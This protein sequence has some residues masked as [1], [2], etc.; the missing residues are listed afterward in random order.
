M[1]VKNKTGGSLGICND[2]RIRVSECNWKETNGSLLQV[3]V[4]EDGKEVR[5]LI[6]QGLCF[7]LLCSIEFLKFVLMAAD[8]F[9]FAAVIERFKA[10][11]Q[12]EDLDLTLQC[13]CCSNASCRVGLTSVFIYLKLCSLLT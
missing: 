2:V 10:A 9:S 12:E 7:T 11:F 4:Q 5:Q 13:C 6:N 1:I 3:F 8:V